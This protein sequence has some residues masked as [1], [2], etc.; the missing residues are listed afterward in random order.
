MNVKQ[1]SIP[2][3]PLRDYLTGI[4]TQAVPPPAQQLAATLQTRYQGRVK[5]ILM[6]GSTLRETDLSD[7]IVDLYV[8]VD[9]YRG[10]PGNAL[11]N[12]LNKLLPPNVFYLQID[13]D[14]MSVRCKYAVISLAQFSDGCN[15]GF[16]S[17][18][19]G[20][21]CQPARLLFAADDASRLSVVDAL[22]GSVLNLLNN[23]C[24]FQPG[25]RLSALQPWISGLSLSYA[26]ELRPEHSQRAGLLVER[27][28]DYYQTV[29]HHSLPLLQD[30]YTGADGGLQVTASAALTKRLRRHWRWRRL[31]GKCL[32]VL[33]LSKAVFTFYDCVDYAAWKIHRHTGELI[34]VTPR[35]RKYPLLFGWR[36]F[37][38]LL[39]KGVLR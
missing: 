25:Q 2:A 21:F 5:A 13:H 19:W 34:E 17:Y 9:D 33:R 3:Q 12:Y 32:S 38:R 22:L 18:L 27:D 24:V 15:D 14:G 4:I 39:R 16:H 28:Q 35:A 30:R 8:L 26:T 6:Y 20:R 10:L 37:Y 7:V 31:S 11:L 1:Q 36:V 29:L 23:A